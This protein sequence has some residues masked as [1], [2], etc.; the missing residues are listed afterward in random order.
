MSPLARIRRRRWA[1]VDQMIFPEAAAAHPDPDVEEFALW[2]RGKDELIPETML[3]DPMH[4]WRAIAAM[5]ADEGFLHHS[6]PG[7][8]AIRRKD[9]HS[10]EA[11][12]RAK[13][14]ARA[15]FWAAPTSEDQ[16]NMWA[17]IVEAAIRAALDGLP[18]SEDV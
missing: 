8:L 5:A 4:F 12:E 17:A 6:A 3:N 11:I 1:K 14:A 16:D 15:E 18:R 13:R 9:M 2:L 10:V 7:L